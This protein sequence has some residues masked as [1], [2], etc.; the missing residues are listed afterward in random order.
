MIEP[1]PFMPRAP[2]VDFPGAYHHVYGRGIEKRDIFVDD[3]DRFVFL[4]RLGGNLK[5]WNLS[6][7][8][9]ALMPNHFHLLLHSRG[10][11]LPFFMR[12]LLTGYSMYFNKRCVRAGHLFQNR[13]QSRIITKESY[14]RA[15]IRYVHLNPLRARQVQTFR[16]LEEYPWT[17]HKYILA[18]DRAGWQDLSAI[19]EFFPGEDDSSWICRYRAFVETGS[20]LEE[21]PHREDAIG[22]YP[23]DTV[24]EMNAG[25]A[26]LHARFLK[27]L[28]VVSMRC[29][30]PEDRI[31]GRARGYAEVDARRQVLRECK[32]RIDVPVALI[33]RWLEISEGAGRYLL[34]SEKRDLD[35]KHV[36]NILRDVPFP[37]LGDQSS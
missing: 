27:I 34:R 28:S 19:R 31:V 25:T 7:F 9:W 32:A 16:Y 35:I 13:Y 10:G 36:G 23:T 6:C 5:R 8:A 20:Y 29:G 14:L 22:A 30:V 18:G 11:E 12:C 24:A 17:G 33:C 26:R 2:R 21:I 37:R 1:A 15:A 4:E 3:R